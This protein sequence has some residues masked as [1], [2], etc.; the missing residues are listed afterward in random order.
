[1]RTTFDDPNATSTSTTEPT[2]G[3]EASDH[4]QSPEPPSPLRRPPDA[5]VLGGLIIALIAIAVVITATLVVTSRDSQTPEV[6]A[7]VEDVSA[8]LDRLIARGYVPDTAF[9]PEAAATD[10]LLIRGLIPGSRFSPEELE[11]TRRLVALG[12][13]P[14][15]R[16]DAEGDAT[17][18]AILSGQ[19]PTPHVG[20]RILGGTSAEIQALAADEAARTTRLIAHGL[21]PDGRFDDQ[22]LEELQRLGLVP[23]PS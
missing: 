23:D 2:A 17:A 4:D 8:A 9:D 3:A 11:A 19:V 10:D 18:A 16:Y 7:P 15:T 20:P 22:M 1:M 13:V 5:T 14:T 12:L 6:E 21:V